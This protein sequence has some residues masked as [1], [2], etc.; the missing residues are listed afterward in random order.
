M[1][2]M[3][4]K[5]N[6]ECVVRGKLSAIVREGRGDGILGEVHVSK[7]FYFQAPSPETFAAYIRNYFVL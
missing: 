2:A 7:S 5:V 4:K 3:F 1:S 6:C